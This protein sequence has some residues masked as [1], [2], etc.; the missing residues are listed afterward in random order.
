M[1][2]GHIK[3]V[4]KNAAQTQEYFKELKRSVQDRLILQGMKKAGKII[5][6]QAKSN[7]QTIKKNKSKTGYKGLNSLFKVEQ[8]KSLKGS[9][10]AGVKIGMKNDNA[11]KNAYHYRFINY[12]TQPRDYTKVKRRLIKKNIVKNHKTGKMKRELFFTN[13]VE[14]KKD[15]AIAIVNENIIAAI[16]KHI[17][18][19]K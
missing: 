13:A 8:M 2:E 4:F 9:T 5:N 6:Q 10:E 14:N 16:N 7:F 19:S 17:L 3:L 11:S 15:E 1:E 18:K 12:G